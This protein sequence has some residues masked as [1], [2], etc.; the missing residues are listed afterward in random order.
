MKNILVLTSG[1]CGKSTANGICTK[2]L[3]NEI[4]QNACSV[5]VIS[6]DVDMICETGTERV[7]SI[8]IPRKAVKK[9]R[10]SKL[11]SIVRLLKNVLLY[12][13]TARYNKNMVKQIVK[14][15]EKLFEEN[16]FD[17]IV[18]MYFPLEAIIAGQIL[19]KKYSDSQFIVFELDSVEDGIAGGGKFNS[20]MLNASRRIMKKL[21]ESCDLIMIL[22]CHETYWLKK[23]SK[24]KERM[25]VTDLPL[26]IPVVNQQEKE[27]IDSVVQFVYAGTLNDFY[28][29]PKHMLDMFE[30]IAGFDWSI[31]FYTK[32]CEKELED[33]AGIHKNV[34]LNGYVEQ[35]VLDTKIETSDILLSIGNK[36]SNSLPS[37]IITYMTFGKPIIHFC[38]QENDICKQYLSKY[39]LSLIIERNEKA[40]YSAQRVVDFVKAHLGNSVCFNELCK[41]FYK[42]LP[43][44]SADIMLGCIN[45]KEKKLS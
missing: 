33:F 25:K 22:Q 40:S 32:G 2:T 43:S 31:D 24:Y 21:Y 17:A 38:L 34:K 8:H 7:K 27:Q 12:S 44:Y 29:S 39:P 41:S 20:Y 6:V 19:K 16:S 30:N 15:S 4:E 26:L 42:N 23:F 28:R 11:R 3:V 14:E 13:Y 10:K 35:S 45:A 18:C 36:V 9:K 37:K 5:H 1:Y